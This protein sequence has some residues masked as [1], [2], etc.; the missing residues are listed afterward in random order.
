MADVGFT[1]IYGR[2]LVAELGAFV[3]RPFL[4]VT[5]E[6]LWGRFAPLLP[7]DALEVRF[8]TS[9]DVLHLDAMVRDLPPVEAVVG[10]GGGRAVDTAKY[11]AWKRRLP[12]FQL[13]TSMSVNAVFGHRAGVRV[14]GDVRYVGYAVPEAV[15]VDLDIIQSAPKLINRSGICEILCYHTGHL[16]WAY[17]RD[18]GMCEPKWPYDQ[19]L[20]DESRAVLDT[21]LANLEHIRDVDETGIRTLMEANRYG[22]ATFMHAGWNPRHI[23]GY[24]HFLFYALEYQTGRSFLHGQP[25]CLGVYVGALLHGQGAEAMLEAIRTTRVDI[26]PEAMGI[27]WADVDRAIT[28]MPEFVRRAG[29]WYGIAHDARP[30]RAF[31]DRLRE[32]VTAAFGAWDG[33]PLT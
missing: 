26:R 12:L 30:D 31:L 29:L 16:D 2:N 3:H 11:V 14:G 8:A 15:F 21:V 6:E 28:T 22:G 17:A 13:P 19:R 20:V 27:T 5:M 32:T 4:V 18:R 9:M 23:E 1:T 24:D 7:A 33:T 10:I 25:V